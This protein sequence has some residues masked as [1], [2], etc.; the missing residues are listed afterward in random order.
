VQRITS[1]RAHPLIE[2]VQIKWSP[3][4]FRRLADGTLVEDEDWLAD[5]A[6]RLYMAIRG[7]RGVYG[8]CD[9]DVGTAPS[10]EDTKLLRLIRAADAGAVAVVLKS[11]P[12]ADLSLA[13]V[14]QLLDCNRATIYRSEAFRAWRLSQPDHDRIQRGLLTRDRSGELTVE[15]TY[16]PGDETE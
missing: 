5:E 13:Q 10:P 7:V 14:A 4:D 6:H 11:G 3:A 8:P 12:A 15:S 2:R 1:L 9:S 16:N